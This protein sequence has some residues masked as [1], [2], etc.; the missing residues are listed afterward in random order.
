MCTLILGGGFGGLATATEL[1]RPLPDGPGGRGEQPLDVSGV[2][3][4]ALERFPAPSA[5]RADASDRP[6][7]TRRIANP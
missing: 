2:A 1:R 7:T 6:E 3:S 4:T 5:A